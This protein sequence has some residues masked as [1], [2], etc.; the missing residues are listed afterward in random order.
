M[1]NF[2]DLFY[3][4]D[5]NKFDLYLSTQSLYHEDAAVMHDIYTCTAGKYNGDIIDIFYN[6][7]NNQVIQIDYSNQN[8][9]PCKFKF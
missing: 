2:S 6:Y 1:Q 4:L 9:K 8:G 3:I 5:E 7:D